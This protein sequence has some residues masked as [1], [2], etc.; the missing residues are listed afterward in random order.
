MR[1]RVAVLSSYSRSPARRR[2]ISPRAQNAIPSPYAGERPSWNQTVSTSP[3]RYLR[4][5]QARR[6]LPIPAGPM[7]DTSRPDPRGSSREEVLE[8]EEVLVAADEGRLEG[9]PVAATDLG[10]DAERPPGGHRR[11][12]A[13][14]SLFAGRLECDRRPRRN[15][16]RPPTSTE[17]GEATDCSRAAVLTM[18]PATIPWFVAPR[19]TAASPVRTPT[20]AFIAGPRVSTISTSSRAART[21]RSASSSCVVGAPQTAITA[22]P[23][24]F[25]TVPP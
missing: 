10:H 13:L 11:G 22:S 3:S 12:L 7:T 18:S 1:S 4:N 17:P 8:Q 2:I 15:G 5:S 21:A 19:V 6:V 23:M 14:S 24:N 16:G 25:S 9:L 20:R